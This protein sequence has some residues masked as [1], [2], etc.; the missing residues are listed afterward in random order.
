MIQGKRILLVED[1]I[2]IA[3]MLEDMI[4]KLEGIPVGP[5]SSLQQGLDLARSETFDAAVLDVNLGDGNSVDIA[6]L[7]AQRQIPFI[8]ATGYGST[9]PNAH[10]APIL[11]KPYMLR[12]LE[13]AFADIFCVTD[14]S[15][16]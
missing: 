11:Q 9:T 13:Q 14:P 5:A 12:D 6:S 4:L 15:S 3:M 1:E 2:V 10:A 8:L 7:L 16:T